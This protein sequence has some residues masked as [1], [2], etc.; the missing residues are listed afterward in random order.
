MEV[1]I[2]Y[3]SRSFCALY[4][5]KLLFVK[6]FNFNTFFFSIERIFINS[7]AETEKLILKSHPRAFSLSDKLNAFGMPYF[8]PP[9][10]NFNSAVINLQASSFSSAGRKTRKFCLF[11]RILSKFGDRLELL[12]SNP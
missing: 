1:D 3:K 9:A 6:N 5:Q 10:H 2:T 4:Y 8:F 12:L 7:A 11:N